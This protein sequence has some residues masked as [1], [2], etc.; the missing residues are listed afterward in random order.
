[1]ETETILL[2]AE[3]KSGNIV[4]PVILLGPP[5]AGKGTQAK[6][7]SQHYGIPQI[8]TGDLLRENIVKGTEFGRRAQA[9]IE[10]GDLAPDDLV[11]QM[12]ADRLSQPDCAHGCILDGFP[13]TVVQAGWLDKYLAENRYFETEK[14]CNQLVVLR[15]VVEYNQLLQRLTGRRTCPTCGRIYNVHSQPSQ[16][17]GVCDVD[18]SALITR[19]DDR[20]DVIVERLNTYER[21]TLPLVN[22]YAQRFRLSEI[23]GAKDLDQVTAEAFKAIEHGNFL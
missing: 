16:V 14:G 20:D 12:V 13:R 5:G 11:C 23:N 19:K 3:K 6:R 9:L 7:I 18:G 4:G 22:Y 15:F 8:S 10:R 21:Q 1:M 2:P 17:E